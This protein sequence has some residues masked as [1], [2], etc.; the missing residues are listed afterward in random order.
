MLVSVIVMTSVL[1]VA[2][3]LLPLA[4]AQTSSRAVLTL[5]DAI[6]LACANNGDIKI[7]G[8]DVSKQREAW[9]KAKTQSY[10]R[11]DTSVLA[12]QLLTPIDFTIDKG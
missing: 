11:F 12:V 1:A 3:Q 9:G 5:D 7:Y 6:A 2:L 4:K 8:L 10:P